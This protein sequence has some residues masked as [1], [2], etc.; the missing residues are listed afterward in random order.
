MTDSGFKIAHAAGVMA[1]LDGETM[2]V[3]GPMPDHKRR[4]AACSRDGRSRSDMNMDFTAIMKN[5]RGKTP[6]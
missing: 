5:V 4:F 6:N 3:I 1:D 2:P